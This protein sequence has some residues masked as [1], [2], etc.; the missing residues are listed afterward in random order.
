MTIIAVYFNPRSRTG[1]DTK[2]LEYPSTYNISIHAPA[3]GA[4]FVG[5]TINGT[6]MISIHAPAQGAT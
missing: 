2:V 6:V 4:T 5:A 3:Q 1:S